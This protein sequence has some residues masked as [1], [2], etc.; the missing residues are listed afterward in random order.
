MHST[1]A[2]V[3]PSTADQLELFFN[4]P[5]SMRFKIE[6]A[7]PD[8]WEHYWKFLPNAATT[9]AHKKR[10]LFFFRG[11]FIDDISK[12]DI[13]DFRRSLLGEGLNPQTVNKAQ[14]LLSRMF[15]KL[16]EWKEGKMAHG[17]DY[18]KLHLPSKNPCALVPRPRPK[19]RKVTA[20]PREFERLRYLATDDMADILNMVYYTR[21][22][23]CDIKIL[24][25]NEVDLKRMKIEMVQHKTITT[26]KPEGIQIV[27]PINQK[28]A[29][30]LLPR[31]AKTEAGKPL[32]PWQNMQKRWQKLRKE[33]GCE[34]LQLGRDFRRTA[35][36]A[37]LDNGVDPYTVA[38]G[39]GHTSLEMLPTYTPRTLTHQQKS[40][41]ILERLAGDAK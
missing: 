34:H 10:I 3:A 26:R 6:D 35:A 25:S 13:E 24:T 8:F 19:G 23:P 27:M 33:A 1:S 7:M 36:T 37:L 38:E 39:L 18:T 20:T 32:F 2:D 16:A 22:R 4:E 41:E 14:M 28:I 40:L 31:L 21:L 9:K 15:T 11:R 17:V 12:A 29:D 5:F 30:I